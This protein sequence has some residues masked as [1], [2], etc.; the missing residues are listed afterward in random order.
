MKKF[1][2]LLAVLAVLFLIVVS[3][4]NCSEKNESPVEVVVAAIMAMELRDLDKVTVYYWG[5]AAQEAK[6][7]MIRLYDRFETVSAANVTAS[8]RYEN[9]IA[10]MVDVAYDLT[11]GAKGHTV[12]QHQQV[13]IRLV[14]IDDKW[15]IKETL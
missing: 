2:I 13:A 3:I 4:G 1:L 8:L 11:V 10:A 12:T 9:D 6:V 7:N 5:P 15:L 14:R